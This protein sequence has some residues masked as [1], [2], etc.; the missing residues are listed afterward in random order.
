M[1]PSRQISSNSL[2]RYCKK[3]KKK[4]DTFVSALFLLW[5][6]FLEIF[7]FDNVKSSDSLLKT[8]HIKMSKS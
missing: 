4:N 6:V 2:L 1:L 5:C 8:K 3:K 7:I